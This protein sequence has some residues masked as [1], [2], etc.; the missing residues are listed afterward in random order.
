MKVFK[1]KRKDRYTANGTAGVLMGCVFIIPLLFS[2]KLNRE[3]A[4]PSKITEPSSVNDGFPETA[5]PDARKAFDGDKKRTV[6]LMLDSTNID[7]TSNASLEVGTVTKNPG[8]PLFVEDQ[9]WEMRFDNFY[10][11]VIYDEDEGIYK[12][13]YS[14]FIIDHSSKG[15]SIEQRSRE[16][17]PPRGRHMGLCYAT[18]K[19][20]VTWE[21]PALGIVEYKGDNQ[22]NIV[23]S[24]PH[25]T[26]I[27]ED[28]VDPD[29]ARKY[30]AIFQGLFVSFS[31]DGLH[32]AE[33]KRIEGIKVAGDTHNYAFWAPTLQKYVGITRS[34]GDLGRQVTRIE[35]TDFEHWT[36]EE[37]VLK[38]KTKNLQPYSMPVFFYGGVYLGLVTIHNQET[39]RVWTE[40]TWSKDTRKWNRISPGT[41]L[42]PN[43]EKE[44]DYDYGCVY[45]C[46]NPVFLEDE[47]RL[48]YGGSDWLHFGWRNGS[49]NLAS[50][51][52][53]G[54]A[55]FVQESGDK[56]AV[57]TTHLMPYAGES[58]LLNADVETGGSIN[59]VVLDDK[60]KRVYSRKNI[61]KTMTNES[62]IPEGKIK[63]GNI[64]LR[65]E[66]KKA[67]VYS[68]VFDNQ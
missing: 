52:P 15:M 44:L 55:G 21:K 50:L 1:A 63:S 64:Q 3:V 56:Q 7:K 37:V 31:Q 19:D 12:C 51:R 9:P 60:G 58:I 11:N 26:G 59:V 53:D 14:P 18:S 30:K 35:S 42:I 32:W 33:R 48:Y 27:F 5:V 6:F 20:G 62:L 41:P 8:N 23:M 47:I 24:G 57:V 16:Y 66:F 61:S 67:K 39:D 28:S 43:S 49:F 4:V 10:G 65:F 45:A 54:F 25:G 17:Q 36:N 13:W 68:V 46:A 40:L 29:P 38:G 22:N 34:F 2:L